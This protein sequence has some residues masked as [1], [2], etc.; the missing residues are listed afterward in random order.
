MAGQQ[1]RA[2]L[3]I[4]LVAG[5]LLGGTVA[6]AAAKLA[7][8]ATTRDLQSLAAA[9][10]G[11]LVTVDGIIP[12]GADPEA[13]EPK[14]GDVT[15]LA[16]ADLV[17]RVGLGFDEWL[18]PVLQ[19][20]TRPDLRRGGA[21]Q[22]DASVGIPL[23]EVH[24][25]NPSDA[26]GH[27]HGLANPHYWLDPENA[28]TITAAIAE[29]IVRVAPELREPVTANRERFLLRLH[30]KLGE[31]TRSLAPYVGAPVV[32]YHNSWPYLARRFRLNVIDFIE[33]K[34]GVAPSPAHLA[35]LVT[36][37]R[38]AGVKAILQETYEPDDAARLLAARTGARIAVLAPGV[39][40]APEASDTIALFDHDVA[41][42]LRALAGAG[43]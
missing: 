28:V 37:M 21:A 31:W 3:I 39:G 19:Q 43:G 30:A 9:V 27:A 5:A 22:V 17:V 8:V 35:R 41:I 16:A 33:P 18:D 26:G 42:L 12:A 11:D 1:Q 20:G 15:R 38:K 7:I 14:P 36:K 13:F 29:G 6:A 2:S 23:L 25:R 10:G 24:G 4:A 40:A 34:E 32:S